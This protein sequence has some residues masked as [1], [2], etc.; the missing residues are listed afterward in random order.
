MEDAARGELEKFSWTSFAVNKE[1]V[2]FQKTYC[3]AIE[4]LGFELVWVKTLG[5]F[6]FTDRRGNVSTERKS[7]YQISIR[8]E[9]R[10]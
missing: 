3:S 9:E 6:F 4:D 10:T 2:H 5:Y 1:V 8:S 7:T